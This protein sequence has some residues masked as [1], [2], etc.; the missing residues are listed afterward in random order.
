MAEKQT[1]MQKRIENIVTNGLGYLESETS[2]DFEREEYLAEIQIYGLSRENPLDEPERFDSLELDLQ[3]HLLSME[4]NNPSPRFK[5]EKKQLY[6]WLID[7]DTAKA[8]ILEQR[9]GI[10]NEI[11]SNYTRLEFIAELVEIYKDK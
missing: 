9:S 3:I 4:L 10:I 7:Y 6:Q 11:R 1:E 5:N 2:L 8:K